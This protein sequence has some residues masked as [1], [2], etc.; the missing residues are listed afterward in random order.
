[1]Q[2]TIQSRDSQ[3]RVADAPSGHWVYRALPRRHWP[4]M[5]A[6]ALCF[7]VVWNVAS[8]Y[9]AILIPSGQAAILGFT[10]PLW[11]AL[12]SWAFL[13]QRP[14]ARMALAL[15]LGVAAVGLLISRGAQAYAD[16]PLGF[17][18]GLLAQ[19]AL[20]GYAVGRS[21]DG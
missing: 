16:A 3:G 19:G 14:Q 7:L 10:M 9:A 12:I 21:Q 5:V 18:L 4:V 15:V 11:L 20:H 8:A 17:F 13:G 6:A 1:M 2:D